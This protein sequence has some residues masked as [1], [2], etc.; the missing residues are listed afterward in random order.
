MEMVSSWFTAGRDNRVSE[1]LRA[2][3]DV[4]HVQRYFVLDPISDWQPVIYLSLHDSDVMFTS[5]VR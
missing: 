5:Q 3:V 2:S 4:D 1:V